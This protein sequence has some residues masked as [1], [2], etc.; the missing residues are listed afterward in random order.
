MSRSHTSIIK[1]LLIHLEIS[2]TKSIFIFIK[3]FSTFILPFLVLVVPLSHA[4]VS[5]V[6]GTWYTAKKFSYLVD[7][8]ENL[9]FAAPNTNKKSPFHERYMTV[10][11]QIVQRP[12]GLITGTSKWT[13]YD[14]NKKKLRDGTDIL[15]GAISH[16][17]IILTETSDI[18]TQFIFDF[19]LDDTNKMS[20]MGYN[21]IGPREV[22]MRFE[23]IK[24]Q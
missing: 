18:N 1:I 22:A 6:T 9:P 12:D 2:M 21:I 3:Y 19:Q 24:K 7:K 23:L 20:G 17:H 10:E 15:L 8:S 11:W 5:D 14:E 13:S 4:A 16:N